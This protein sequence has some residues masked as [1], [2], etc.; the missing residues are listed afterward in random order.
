MGMGAKPKGKRSFGSGVVPASAADRGDLQFSQKPCFYLAKAV[1]FLNPLP[2]SFPDHMKNIAL[3]WVVIGGHA[4][5]HQ[6]R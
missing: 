2:E 6:R 5:Q 4:K 3:K 1:S